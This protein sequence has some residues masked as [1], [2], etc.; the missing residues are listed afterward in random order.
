MRCL[1]LLRDPA[2]ARYLRNGFREMGHVVTVHGFD[3]DGIRS[4]LDEPWELLLIELLSDTTA[5]SIQLVAMLRRTGH[6]GLVAMLGSGADTATVVRALHEG[7]DEYLPIPIA[8]SELY[9]RIESRARR[10]GRPSKPDLLQVGDLQIDLIRRQVSRAGIRIPM[11]PRMLRLLQ[12]LAEQARQPVAREVLLKAVWGDQS[13]KYNAV[14][15][16]VSRIRA[17]IETGFPDPLLHTVRGRGYML[18]ECLPAVEQEVDEE[19]DG[20]RDGSRA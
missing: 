3:L 12:T 2:L 6:E 14:D 13:V 15:L 7:A 18:S 19:S 11:Q 20:L 1:I 4:A 5:D 16:L 10:F 8:F 17:R 9:A